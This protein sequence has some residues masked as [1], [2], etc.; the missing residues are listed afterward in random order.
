MAKL[1]SG[2][3]IYGTATIDTS[4]VVGSAV[5]LSSSGIQVTGIVTATQLDLTAS[6]TASDSVLYLSGAP[7]GSSGTNG[8]FGIGALSFSDTD[9]IANFTHNVNSYAQ[10]V[11]Q[12]KNSGSSSSADIIVNNDRSAGT[13]YYGDFGI[14]GTTFSGG[15]PFGDVDGTYLYSAGGTLSLGSLNAYD[16]KIA[17][18]NTE[19]V[20][21]FSTGEVGI[22]TTVL[23][24]TA[25]Q[26]LQVTGGAYVS[27]SVGI[28]TT[29]PTAILTVA[30]NSANILIGKQ[31]ATANSITLNG[32]TATADYNIL[33]T[34]TNNLFINRP[35]GKTITF[36]QADSSHAN[37]D[38]SNNFILNSGNLA[39]GNFTPT[40]A[41]DAGAASLNK[42]GRVGSII[43]GT[44]GTSYGIVGYNAKPSALNAWVYD[45]TDN[46]SW[47]QFLSGGHV[48]YRAASGT[49]GNAITPLESG[50]FNSIGNLGIGTANPT[51]KLHVIGDGRFT[52][53]VT[54]TTFSGS[55]ENAATFN[56]GGAGAVSGTTFNGS[57][58]QTISYNTLGASP[59][60]GSS[61]L[62]TTGTVTSGTW[63]GSFGAVSGA[64]LTSLNAT[65]LGSGTV[66]VLRLGNSGTRDATTF[67]RGDNTWATAGGSIT[68][69]DDTSTNATRYLT[70]E[71][72]TSGTSSSI[73]VSSTKLTF[74]PS[75]GTLSATQ[76]TSLSDINKKKNIRPIE[77]AIEI[78][79]KLEG[80]RFDW[81]DTDAPSLG[82]IAQEVEKVLP[83]LVVESD[84]V[85]S[86]S[87][88]NLVGVLIEAI[89]EQQVRIE[90][91]ERKLNA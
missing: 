63:S 62:V 60:A 20:R 40:Y 10:L 30:G 26:R 58:A 67:L 15:G 56:N 8:L 90:E 59:L 3:R 61:S 76:F 27:G 77:N 18:N 50:R 79:K 19:R 89:K 21:I 36:A 29:N 45:A 80:V 31:Y 87:Y 54:A 52:G 17:T 72:V 88:G 24:G 83:E 71:D 33:S 22:G 28:G 7:T 55:L 86:V 6:A 69:S 66:P 68:V 12:N 11:V 64:N 2:T 65:N 23:T 37:F 38:T 91:L 13:T 25:S 53:I 35:S 85:K 49:A 44:A 32:S 14:N 9:I 41:I 1:K 70:F 57:V 74:N 34:S 84:G 75:T 51:S 47:I 4:V 73:N 82:V 43:F 46:A 78:T 42:V 5:T 48:F 39:I 16:V 81:K